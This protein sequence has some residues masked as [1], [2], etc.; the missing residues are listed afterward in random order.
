VKIAPR[1]QLP[2]GTALRLQILPAFS[3]VAARQHQ[4][5]PFIVDRLVVFGC[6]LIL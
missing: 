5:H 3:S 6:V 4:L 2:E 1:L